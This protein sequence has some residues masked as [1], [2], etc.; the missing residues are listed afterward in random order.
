MSLVINNKFSRNIDVV[1]INFNKLT[2]QISKN[3]NLYNNNNKNKMTKIN[4]KFPW[5]AKMK[6]N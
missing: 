6:W 2:Y 5:I 4:F 1:K 3:N